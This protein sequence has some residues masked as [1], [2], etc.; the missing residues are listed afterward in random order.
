MLN[1]VHFLNE[2][3]HLFVLKNEELR[4]ESVLTPSLRGNYNVIYAKL[5]YLCE[6]YYSLQLD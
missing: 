6:V 4:C 3:A 2:M 1:F 5:K